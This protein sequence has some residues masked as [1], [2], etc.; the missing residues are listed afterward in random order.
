VPQQIAWAVRKNSPVLKDNL[1][2]WMAGMKRSGTYM[3]IYNR[4]FKSPRTSLIRMT[5]DYSSLNT[6]GKIS[7]YDDWIKEGATKL[8]WD[9][10]LLAAVVYQES[11][12]ISTGIS[13]AGARGLMQL[14]PET[15]KHFGANNPDNP[16][17]S[18][19][20]GVNFLIYLNRQWKG[21]IPDDTERLKFVLASYNAG[22][23][24][25][26][27]AR[28]LTE[29]YSKDPNQWYDNVEFYLLKKS[30]PKFYR[31]PNLVAGYCKCEET[32]NYVRNV[33]E[34]YEEYKIHY[35]S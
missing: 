33:L 3:V 15:A 18:L 5:S 12:F 2:T 22:L 31:D 11:H 29:K 17:Q 4:Y 26:T 10:R 19:R 14:M 7:P 23:T 20:A 8:G 1:N 6:D 32:V 34:R 35:P 16:Q 13:W 27:D 9:W 24:H 30:D 21:K 25:V 28:K